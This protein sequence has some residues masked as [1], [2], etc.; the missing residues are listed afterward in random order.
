MMMTKLLT[1]W[2]VGAATL[3]VVAT[4]LALAGGLDVEDAES[5]RQNQDGAGLAT[6]VVR[7]EGMT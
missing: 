2:K 3:V 6:V 5:T 4:G 7:V 1:W